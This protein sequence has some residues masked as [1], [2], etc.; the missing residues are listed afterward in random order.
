MPVETFST[1]ATRI[2]NVPL[3]GSIEVQRTKELFKLLLVNRI[4][5]VIVVK[6]K[7]RHAMVLN[8]VFNIWLL[9]LS[10]LI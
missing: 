5:E 8:Q 4:G 9:P 10:T 6:E 2:G 7:Q 3:V 1:V